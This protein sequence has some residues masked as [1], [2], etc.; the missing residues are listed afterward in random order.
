MTMTKERERH[1]GF[2]MEFVNLDFDQVTPLITQRFGGN[3]EK[4]DQFV[5]KV[6]DTI[7][8]SFTL[9][10]D[11]SFIKKRDYRNW[12]DSF[13]VE[14]SE[15]TADQIDD[16]VMEYSQALVPR[17]LVTPPIGLRH[18][19]T[20]DDLVKDMQALYKKNKG[21]VWSL[22][23]CGLHL[24][25]ECE[26]LD[27]EYLLNTLRAFCFLYDELVEDIGVDFTRR[28][29]PYIRAFPSDY[30][31]VISDKSYRPNMSQFVAD[32][33]KYNPTRNRPL[34][35]TVIFAH[36]DQRFLNGVDGLEVDLI[37]PRPA[38]HYRLPNCELENE[39]WSIIEE[40]ERWKK[41]E[42]LARELKGL[43]EERWKN[44]TPSKVL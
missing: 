35:M 27:V 7:Y 9:E 5:E 41:V 10:S 31:N 43:C 30:V 28:V 38:F 16:Q 40:W 42:S 15:E 3:V 19:K 6:K 36:I 26:S 4:S 17:E 25:I 23:P 33:F 12:L 34:D 22:A 21:K 24:N 13:G 1:V 2:E 32:Y 20:M 29:A 44:I 37:K 18:I 39:E 14:L 8:G 11:S